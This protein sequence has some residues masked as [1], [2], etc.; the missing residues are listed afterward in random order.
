M[1]SSSQEGG[2]KKLT[3]VTTFPVP[4]ALGEIKE[5]IIISASTSSKPSKEQIINQAFKLHSQGNFSEAAKLYQYLINQGGNDHRVFNNYGA[6]LKDLGKLQEAENSYRKAIKLNP[7]F[8]MAHLNLGL[9]LKDLGKSKD[10]ELALKKAIELNPNNG[11]SHYALST[12][13]SSNNNLVKAIDEINLAIQN[14]P[15]NYD[16]KGE[17]TRLRYIKGEFDY[18][19]SSNRSY[20]DQND[21]LFEDNNENT[22]L[23]IFGGNGRNKNKA[24]SFDFLN[25]LK[26][27]N[28][29]DKLFLR[30]IKRNYYLNGLKNSTNNLKQ[31]ID[32]LK[33]LTSHKEYKKVVAIGSSAG[34][35]AAI[36]F[37]TILKLQ[38]VIAFNPQTIISESNDLN[39]IPHLFSKEM[40]SYLG[41]LNTSDKF[42]QKCLNLKNFIPFNTQVEIHYSE[43]SQVDKKQ[44]FF[45]KHQNCRLIKYKS[46]SHLLTVELKEKGVLKDLIINSLDL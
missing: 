39:I 11:I 1:G 45:I 10:A 34:G 23:I 18:N 30:D 41:S 4:C 20:T 36:L 42:Y 2:N 29:F 7:N 19:N 8:G 46:G 31:T 38:K 14:D 37:G 16:F 22:L 21:Y 35:F 6:S 33:K 13:Y 3:E 28:S 12:L 9:I 43:F 32:L 15:N 26:E 27:N 40:S 24:Q 44:A 17:L 25:F 5:S